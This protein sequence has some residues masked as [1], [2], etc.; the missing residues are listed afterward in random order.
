MLPVKHSV[1]FVH[2]FGLV[3]SKR[4]TED[5][6]WIEKLQEV[7]AASLLVRCKAAITA[8]HAEQQVD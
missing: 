4:L 8:L 5:F 7:V 2:D 6:G 3:W 1:S